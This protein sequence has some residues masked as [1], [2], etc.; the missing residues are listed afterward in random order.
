[1]GAL[2]VVQTNAVA[3]RE[4]EFNDWYV[5][6]H[7]PDVLA[8]DGFSAAR[9]YLISEAQR[10]DAARQHPYRHLALYEMSGDPQAALDEL[11]AAVANGMYLSPA[12]VPQRHSVV[13]EPTTEWIGR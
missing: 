12:M 1:M 7:I 10:S 3:G 11:G 4:D 13:F 2:F 5:N 9:R 6:Q 8:L